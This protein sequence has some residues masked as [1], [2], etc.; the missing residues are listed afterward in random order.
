MFITVALCKQNNKQYSYHLKT[1]SQQIVISMR[2]VITAL[3]I[4]YTKES[5]P[6]FVYRVIL[7][8]L[9]PITA[10]FTLLEH[11]FSILVC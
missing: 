2:L 1:L 11:F 8:L 4:S 6:L 5:P 10:Q 3:L 9:V 7:D